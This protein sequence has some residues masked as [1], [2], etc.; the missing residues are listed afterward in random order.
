MEHYYQEMLY[1]INRQTFQISNYFNA[2]TKAYNYT[3]CTTDLNKLTLAGYFGSE[4]KL[5]FANDIDGPKKTLLTSK[6]TNYFLRR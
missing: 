6:V 1:V 2:E 5:H 4:H 3:K